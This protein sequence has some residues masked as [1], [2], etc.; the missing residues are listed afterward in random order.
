MIELHKRIYL[1][2][3]ERSEN[4][5]LLKQQLARLLRAFQKQQIGT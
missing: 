3:L 5:E 2:G 4:F 1:K